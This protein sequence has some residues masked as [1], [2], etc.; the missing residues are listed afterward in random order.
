M[1]FCIRQA[2]GLVLGAL[3]LGILVFVLLFTGLLTLVPAAASG[4]V[5]FTLASLLSGGGVLALA[6]GVLRTERTPALTDAW[7]CCGE[8]AAISALAAL[9][10][11]LL[12]A[13]TVSLEVGLYLGVSLSFFFLFLFFGFLICFLRRY[14]TARFCS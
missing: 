12:T 6:L 1:R 11:S 3:L 2:L 7:L 4:I 5:F 14:V 10:T 9:L 8:A 13:L